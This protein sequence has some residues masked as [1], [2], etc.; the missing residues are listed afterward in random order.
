MSTKKVIKKD[1]LEK[2]EEKVLYLNEQPE[3]VKAAI[4]NA[5]YSYSL[6]LY[7][8]NGDNRTSGCHNFVKVY[9]EHDLLIVLPH[10]MYFTKE[11][12]STYINILA[13]IG[14]DIKYNGWHNV[15]DY[16]KTTIIGEY[17]ALQ[18]AH[19]FTLGRNY[20]DNAPMCRYVA[21]C[22]LRDLWNNH[23]MWRVVRTLEYVEYFS[24]MKTKPSLSKILVFAS[25]SPYGLCSNSYYPDIILQKNHNRETK[26]KFAHFAN[27]FNAYHSFIGAPNAGY[28]TST[29]EKGVEKY[30]IFSILLAADSKFNLVTHIENIDDVDSKKIDLQNNHNGSLNNQES[31]LIHGG[32]R[33]IPD[34]DK[35][36]ENQI[37]ELL[38]AKEYYKAYMWFRNLA[39]NWVRNYS[40]YHFSTLPDATIKSTGIFHTLTNEKDIKTFISKIDKKLK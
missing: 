19:I 6:K 23:T 21:L 11:Q 40:D 26:A 24:R 20:K 27:M 13:E 18:D 9:T 30:F 10:Q 36:F 14:F 5:T 4:T 15:K 34:I 31:R 17:N 29:S 2:I 32:T 28:Q 39:L 1:I 33:F 38:K 3:F 7:P 37:T 35:Y 16:C 12:I 22:F 8:F 25:I